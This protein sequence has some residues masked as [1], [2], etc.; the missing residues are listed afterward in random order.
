[1]GKLLLPC[2]SKIV[3]QAIHEK[4]SMN[5]IVSFEPWT[6]SV[7]Q[8]FIQKV[9][10]LPNPSGFR[11]V[12]IEIQILIVKV[13]DR[14]RIDVRES[15][16]HVPLGQEQRCNLCGELPCLASVITG[17]RTH[18]LFEEVVARILQHVGLATQVQHEIVHAAWHGITPFLCVQG[19]TCLE[20]NKKVS[21]LIGIIG[22]N[23]GQQECRLQEAIL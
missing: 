13:V 15:Q 19:A 4:S 20:S 7:P 22:L 9:K 23:H 2:R 5:D 8:Q 10:D 16:A 6:L 12:R 3:P 17:S 21:D 1:M 14:W 11:S 18:R